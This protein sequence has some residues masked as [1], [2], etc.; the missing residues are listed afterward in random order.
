MNLKLFFKRFG[1]EGDL[2]IFI[3]GSG[4]TVKNKFIIAAHCIHIGN[5][6]I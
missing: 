2:A 4:G 1:L 6:A 3:Q 5:G